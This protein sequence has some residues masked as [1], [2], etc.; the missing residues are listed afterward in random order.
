MQRIDHPLLS[1][2]LGC[3]KTLTSFHFGQ[4][5]TGLK[6][7]IQASLHAE[8]LPGMLTAHHLFAKLLAAEAADALRGQVVLVPAANPIGLAQRLDHKPMGRFE[9]DSSEN[10]NR[11][12]PDLASAVLPAVRDALGDDAL[13]QDALAN[14]QIVRRAIGNYLVQWRPATEL[15]GLRK[16]LLTL[17]HDADYMLDLHCDCEGVLHF[18][19]E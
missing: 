4:P 1:P 18:Y 19:T 14:V 6:I 11:H 12:Y 2:S 16:T 10:F 3:H 5:G 9:Q 15:Q 8:E 7:Y 17:S 13:G